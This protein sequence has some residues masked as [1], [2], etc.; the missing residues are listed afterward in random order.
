MLSWLL[1]E[2][3]KE[4]HSWDSQ[5]MYCGWGYELIISEVYDTVD[6]TSICPR[7]EKLPYTIET[8]TE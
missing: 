6:W 4:L 7:Q 3:Y 8:V 1:Q 2:K 5:N